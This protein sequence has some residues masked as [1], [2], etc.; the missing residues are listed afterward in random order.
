MAGLIGFFGDTGLP[1]HGFC[2]LWEPALIWLHV[3]SDGV[4]GVSYFAIPLALA[5]FVMRRADLAFTWIFWLFAAFILLCGTTH[6][7]AI[8]VLWH[9]DYALEGLVKAITATVSL[10]TAVLLWPLVMRAIPYPT[11]AQFREMTDRL[12]SANEERQRVEASLHRSEQSLRVLLDGVTDHA[13]FMLDPTGAVSSWNAG[14]ARIKGYAGREVMG[15]HFSMFYT[16]E[17]RAAGVPARAL[18][19]AARDGKYEAEGWR[20]RKDGSRFWASVVIERLRN[21]DGVL[22]GFAKITRDFTE[23]RQSAQALEQARM[24]LAQAQKMETVGQ[25]TGGVAHDF[26]NLLTAILGGADLLKRR[27]PNLDETTR[28]VLDGIIDTSQRGAA[29]VNRLLAF[30]RK[31]ALRPEVTDVNRLIA[32]MSELLRRTIGEGIKVETVLAGDLWR[33]SIDRNQ[34]ENTILNLAVNARDAMPDGGKLTIETG[35]VVLDDD[36]AI[37]NP[38]AR[39]G[40]FLLIAVSDSGTGMSA[41]VRQRAFEPFFTTKSEGM[42]T[43]LGL[44]QV[45]G[46]MQQSGGS[47]KIYSEPGQ[48]TTVKLYL[49][50]QVGEGETAA[51]P[52]AHAPAQTPRGHETVLVVEDHA[53][54]RDYAA[55]ALAHLGYHVLQAADAETGL[56]LLDQYPEIAVLFTD[57]GLPGRSGRALAEEAKRRRPGLKVLY[58]T[59]YARTAIVHHGILD[60]G[61][62]LLP[63]PYTL[64]GLAAK[65]RVVLDAAQPVPMVPD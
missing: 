49:P 34:L 2:L 45:Y 54:V 24:A 15:R 60:F 41:E 21:Q 42:G 64:Q 10:V 30:S 5:Y 44:S 26:N 12:A 23:R 47:V 1:P 19:R 40:R 63:K 61:A 29:L 11:P 65:L 33:T 32:G 8:W 52:G 39:S 18:E 43:G 6:L 56:A 25:L 17:D 37:A 22:V 58:T 36:Y 4:I 50:R 7:F 48:G 14:A 62:H 38:E 3:L 51:L 27:V 59:G 28:R 9:G 31:Q 53:D 35:N 16:P 13:I 20:I 55:N 57:V 46:F